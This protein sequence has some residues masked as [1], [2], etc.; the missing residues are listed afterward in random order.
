MKTTIINCGPTRY[1]EDGSMAAVPGKGINVLNLALYKGAKA[2]SVEI[3][4]EGPV[5]VFINGEQVS[6]HYNY[7][8][9]RQFYRKGEGRAP[10]GM[11]Y[12]TITSLE[13][14]GTGKFKM[15]VTE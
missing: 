7:G 12:G 15:V 9:V 2:T 3:T 11:K 5:E 6:A 4:A 13:I 10:G 8:D 1:P 14:A